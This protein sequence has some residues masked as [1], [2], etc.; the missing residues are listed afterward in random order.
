L[1]SDQTKEK[2][3]ILNMISHTKCFETLSMLHPPV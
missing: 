3:S 2:L 1:E